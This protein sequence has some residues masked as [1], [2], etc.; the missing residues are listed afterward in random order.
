MQLRATLHACHL[1][2]PGMLRRGGGS[3]VFIGA[4]GSRSGGAAG[5]AQIAAAKTAQDGLARVLVEELAPLGIR[6]NTVAPGTVFT[7]ANDNEHHRAEVAAEVL[8]PTGR[9][10]R[11]DDVAGAVVAM[12][13]DLTRQMAGA[14][15]PVDGGKTLM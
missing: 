7:D 2:L 9:V 12:I 14:F 10:S 15:L 1:V 13:S 3:I 8:P 6:V 5:M 4:A 11:P